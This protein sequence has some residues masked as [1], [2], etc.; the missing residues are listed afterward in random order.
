[1]NDPVSILLETF[2]LGTISFS[3]L[4]PMVR[5]G[6]YDCSV[7]KALRGFNLLKNG[8]V[9]WCQLCGFWD[10]PLQ[11]LRIFE[12]LESFLA[13]CT[14]IRPGHG[15]SAVPWSAERERVFERELVG[16]DFG[17][18]SL[19]CRVPPLSGGCSSRRAVL[20]LSAFYF[21]FFPLCSSNV[22]ST[23]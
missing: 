21:S 16:Q 17:F 13:T 18:P 14:A 23:F 12:R 10:G 19:E 22:V 5:V 15:S 2:L 3:A 11:Q 1:M 7:I 6:G 4:L 8:T 20:V 9:G